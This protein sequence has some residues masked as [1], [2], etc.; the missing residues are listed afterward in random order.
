MHWR[1][2]LRW[3][4]EYSCII[5]VFFLKLFSQSSSV[6]TAAI[7]KRNKIFWGGWW[8]LNWLVAMALLFAVYYYGVLVI[9]LIRVASMMR[10]VLVVLVVWVLAVALIRV[11]SMVIVIV[12][13][14]V[15]WVPVYLLLLFLK[16][17]E[18]N[19]WMSKLRLLTSNRSCFL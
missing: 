15:V 6:A 12:V 4:L 11:V 1:Q 9:A 3:F 13:V 7:V 8:A 18:N 10:V 14:L 2:S 16:M 19:F 5:T 17:R